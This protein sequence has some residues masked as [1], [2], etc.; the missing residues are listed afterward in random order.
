MDAPSQPNASRRT[1]LLAHLALGRTVLLTAAAYYLTGRIGLA[2][3][4]P[5]G[6][7]TVI[8]PPAGI[9]LAAVLLAGP[10]ASVG[11]FLGSFLVNLPGHVEGETI[12]EFVHTALVASGLAAGIAAGAV[13]QAALGA[14]LAS[15][16]GAYPVTAAGS[17]SIARLYAA[18][19]LIG[20]LVSCSVGVGL[21]TAT[22]Q[23]P[24]ALAPHSW[25]V[26][27]SGDVVGVIAITPVMLTFALAPA[28]QKW[29][30]AA[31]PA[32]ASFIAFLLT[33]VLVFA[34]LRA[35]DRSQRADFAALS[36]EAGTQVAATVDLGRHAVEGLAGA[37]GTDRR[38][39][40]GEF[41]ALADRLAAFGLGIQAL[42]WIPRVAAEDRLAAESELSGQWERPF[43][44][45]ERGA[46]GSPHPAELRPEY[47]P[48]AYATPLKGNEGAVGFDLASN[49]ARQAA[50]KKAEATGEAVATAG[51]KLVQTSTMGILLFVPVYENATPGSVGQGRGTVKGFA[52]GVFS[53]PDLVGVTMRSELSQNLKYQL[54]DETDAKTA[55][56]TASGPDPRAPAGAGASGPFAQMSPLDVVERIKVA[57][58]TWALHLAP[59]QAYLD[60]R[61]DNSPYYVLLGGLVIM[62]L[63]SGYFLTVSEQQYQLVDSREQDLRNQKFALDQHAIVSITDT[64]GVITYANDRFSAVSGYPREFLIGAN[65]NIVNSGEHPPEFYREIWSRLKTG[66]VWR[67]E[68]CDRNAA[69]DLYWLAATLVPLKDR[70]GKLKEF[71][72][73]CT[74]V[75]AR[76]R[77][78]QDLEQSRAFLQSVTDS[79]GE[80][81]YTLDA[82]GRCTFLNAEG[83]RLL[84]WNFEELKG[85]SL[86]DLVHYQNLEGEPIPDVACAIINGLKA[87]GAYHSEDQYFTHRNGKLFPVSIVAKRIVRNGEGLGAVIVFQ[88]IT[89]R[90]RVHD[91]MRLSEERLSV[92]LSAASTG[93]WDYNPITGQA[94]YSDTWFRMLGHEPKPDPCDGEMFFSLLHPDDRE[95]YNLALASHV[96]EGAGVVECEFRMRRADGEWAWVR[97]TGKMIEVD[98]DGQPLRIVGVHVDTTA[99]HAARTELANAT[100]AAIRANQAKD[101]Q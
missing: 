40:L 84:G 38:P 1:A 31:Q 76:K 56:L 96:R 11:V 90:R 57:D 78:E 36:R 44:I 35:I 85:R 92:A 60:R 45:F 20:C 15:R 37:F 28:G 26:W 34:D 83:E 42:E 17:G 59:S 48:V 89:E 52:L 5:P 69:G 24:P 21:L 19:G 79:M 9:A 65:H 72:A 97:S 30:R 12:R 25:L 94:Y 58:R 53:V 33:A 81:V 50:L 100:E 51:V 8:W 86:H 16:V 27:W 95:A 71:I 74:D 101:H 98:D 93:L 80:G 3:A 29:R 4:I 47:F 23:I 46:D 66:Q 6:Y 91:R 75:T 2:L 88:D 67:G 10:R 70:D 73:I 68:I 41:R 32:A 87:N 43:A 39:N 55:L 77:L 99:S 7:A 82:H 13:A 54:V 49:P 62:A 18:G 61:A 64:N 14:R 22:G 63:A